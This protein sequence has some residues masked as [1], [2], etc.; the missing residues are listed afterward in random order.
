MYENWSFQLLL[1][2]AHIVLYIQGLPH[3]PIYA[4]TP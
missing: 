1:E 4:K 2:H 3:K